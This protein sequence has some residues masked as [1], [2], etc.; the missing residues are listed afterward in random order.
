MDHFTAHRLLFECEVV[1]PLRLNERAGSAIRGAFFHALRNG[2]CAFAR[3]RE[4]QCARC[5]LV[6]A[7][8]V[9][10]LAGTL[11]DKS[12]RGADVPRPYTIQPPPADPLLLR[13]NFRMRR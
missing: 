3:D 7:C 12:E 10:F 5:A 13:R 1:T 4:T 6:A 2:F 11:D 9:A 8:P